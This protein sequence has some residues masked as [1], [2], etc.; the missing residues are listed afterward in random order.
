M[1][2]SKA[3]L[4]AP[5]P[6]RGAS[7]AWVAV[8]YLAALGGGVGVGYALAEGGGGAFDAR[9]SPDAPLYIA[10][11]A[12]LAMTVVVY[13]F[14]LGKGNS[15]F[16]DAY[17]SVAPM[18][19]AGYWAA[20]VAWL[21][22]APF[23]AARVALVLAAVCV[24]GVRLTWNWCIGWT[25]LDHEDWRYVKIRED[26]TAK[27]LGPVAYWTLGSFLSLHIFPTVIVF[28][29][30]VP[31]FV[32]VCRSG[33]APV[34]AADVVGAAMCFLA[35]FIEWLSDRQMRRWR[36]ARTA[37]TSPAF[38]T[39]GLWA[40][41]R[42]P[43]YFGECLFW[44]GLYVLSLQTQREGYAVFS[45]AG[46]LA[47]TLMFV[48]ASVPMMDERS[49]ARRPGFDGYCTQVSALVPLPW[50]RYRA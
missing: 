22:P 13:C 2:A 45:F 12:D 24:W 50:R 31:A 5:A 11:V 32:A 1:H 42:H 9:S 28:F 25:G 41:S 29:A 36:R 38:C 35:T 16:Y 30:L 7:F 8:A 34:G 23:N 14:S 46:A 20:A 17:W 39:D 15:S 37:A 49:R 33:E 27:G 6:S 4:P 43:N 40:Y 18:Y 48:F 47:I 21:Q 10:A 3:L 26:M 19:L 44:W